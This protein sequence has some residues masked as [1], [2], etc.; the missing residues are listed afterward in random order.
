LASAAA[1]VP[2]NGLGAADAVGKYALLSIGMSNTTQD[3]CDNSSPLA[4]ESYSFVGQALDHPAVNDASLVLANGAKGG[5]PAMDWDSPDDPEYDRV[6]DEVL[7]AL[8]LSEL[9]V[10]AAW[11]KVANPQPEVSLPDANADAYLL[12]EQ[13][14]NIARALKVRYPNLQQVYLSSRIYAGYA[15]TTL[16]P[17]PYAYES[18]FAAKWLIESQ[19]HQ[20]NGGGADP[21]AGNLDY[22]SSVAPWISW[23]LWADGLNPRSDGLI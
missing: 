23:G 18:G 1:I 19:I 6:R 2:R 22:T 9:Q 20:M 12:V 16:N 21:L 5:K 7:P 13:I 3:F 8:G 14:G 11:V 17:E 15:P 10:G 4:C